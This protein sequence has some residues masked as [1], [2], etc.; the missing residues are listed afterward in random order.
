M[1]VFLMINVPGGLE[2]KSSYLPGVFTRTKSRGSNLGRFTVRL[3][4]RFIPLYLGATHVLIQ[5]SG[6]VAGP[7]I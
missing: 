6:G 5:T 4:R 7:S 2:P 3:L 1:A